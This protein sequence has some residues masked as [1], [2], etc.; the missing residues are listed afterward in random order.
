MGEVAALC[1]TLSSSSLVVVEAAV[2]TSRFGEG[3]A[4]EGEALFLQR[5]TSVLALALHT[6]ACIRYVDTSRVRGAPVPVGDPIAAVLQRAVVLAEH[7]ASVAVQ[8][9]AVAVSVGPLPGFPELH[10]LRACLASA[11]L[12]QLRLP[13]W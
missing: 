5:N 7:A 3:V 2:T 9:V 4:P 8:L 10:A 1:R 6:L 11:S 13:G 12:A